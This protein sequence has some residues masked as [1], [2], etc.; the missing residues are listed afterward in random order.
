LF[1][2]ADLLQSSTAWASLWCHLILC[3]L[4]DHV[5]WLSLPCGYSGVVS[6]DSLSLDF[7]LF[8]RPQSSSVSNNRPSIQMSCF[9][10]QRWGERWG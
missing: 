7:S 3:L 1:D 9:S 8:S 10:S 2:Y 6:Q 4:H 5:S